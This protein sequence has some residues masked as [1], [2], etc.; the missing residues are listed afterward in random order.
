MPTDEQ[1]LIFE[2][3]ERLNASVER[4]KL[5]KEIKRVQETNGGNIF[6]IKRRT[7]E[8]FYCPELGVEIQKLVFREL[9]SL[10]TRWNGEG[11]EQYYKISEYGRELIQESMA[12]RQI[13]IEEEIEEVV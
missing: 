5:F 6:N 11:F 7:H 2:V 10:E 12:K 4:E 3:L 1:F 9:I 13:S 8:H